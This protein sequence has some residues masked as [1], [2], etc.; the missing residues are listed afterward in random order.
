[1]STQLI[2]YILMNGR[3][4]EAIEYYKE[5]LN[6]DVLFKQTFGEGPKDEIAN[7]KENELNLIAHSVLKI[8]E[9]KIMIADS[10]PE[11]PFKNGN[12]VSI[13]ITTSDISLAKQ[14]YENLKKDGKVLI[15]LNEIYF[16]PAYG[17]I[18][19]KFGVTFQIYTN[20]N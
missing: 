4:N 14:F 1:M 12:Q 7:L 15:E 11:L 19:D 6:A 13:C 10:I 9:G 8:G 20:R 3:A 2:A 16:S 17:M 5:A 18:T